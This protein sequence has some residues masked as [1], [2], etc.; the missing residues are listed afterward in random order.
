MR[1]VVY[2]AGAVG[3]VVGAGLVR[4]ND[5]V[6]LIARG[7]HLDAMRAN[8]L[9]LDT[10]NGSELLAVSTVGA[11]SEI[12]WRDDDVVLLAMKSQHTASAVA[13]LAE[14]APP[15][16]AVA[17]VQNGVE[18]ERSVARWFA[19]VYGVVVM[20]PTEHLVPGVVA[21]YSAPVF[22][23]LDVGRS[24]SGVDDRSN[25][26]AAALTRANFSS[27]AIENVMAW[28]YRKLLMN[29]GNVVEAL[30]TK[31]DGRAELTE[32][33]RAEGISCLDVAAI[34]YTSEAEDEARRAG[35]LMPGRIDG[36]ARDGG[37]TWQSV[38]R[39]AGSLE[40]PYLNG[41]IVMLGRMFGVPTPA[42]RAVCTYAS[43]AVVEG[44]GPNTVASGDLLALAARFS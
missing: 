26:I 17:C 37:S 9:R 43:R 15:E 18:N 28:K 11:P 42:N 36:R 41:E 27:I 33:L 44:G 34:S 1:F 20:A 39:S 23:V 6:V 10:P 2:G 4:G 14:H 40:T 30:C 5:D 31:D 32:R 21:A 19:N 22:G 38:A 3:G 8:G 29:L 35:V 24:P 12:R 7:P 13:E 25:A 16:I